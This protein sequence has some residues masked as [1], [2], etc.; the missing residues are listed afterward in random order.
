M[1]LTGRKMARNR[2]SWKPR[3]TNIMTENPEA[4]AVVYRR[5]VSKFSYLLWKV[6]VYS[7]YVK[8]R[9]SLTGV[10][11]CSCSCVWLRFRIFKRAMVSYQNKSGLHEYCISCGWSE[12]CHAADQS[13]KFTL[14]WNCVCSFVTSLSSLK[15]SQDLSRTRL[16]HLL[17]EFLRA[18][19]L[20]P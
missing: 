2:C 1:V 4:D 14:S 12:P 9:F 5:K 18:F 11:S 20:A 17:V 19:A 10:L 3:R 13:S 6:L 16:R 8:L 15:L 7:F